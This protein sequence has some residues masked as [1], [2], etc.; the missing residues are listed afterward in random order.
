MTRQAR[1]AFLG[2][3]LAAAAGVTA[4]ACGMGGEDDDGMVIHLHGRLSVESTTPLQSQVDLTVAGSATNLSGTGRSFIELE[5]P[6]RL[7]STASTWSV[8]GT[9]EGNR[10][11]L[12]GV[13][14][15]AN[16]PDILGSAVTVEF[17]VKTG[18]TDWNMG[19]FLG[20]PL[21]SQT[22]RSKGRASVAVRKMELSGASGT[23]DGGTP[24]GTPGNMGAN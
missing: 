10:V 21:K 11:H 14:L 2:T 5:D 23:N 16:N 8:T 17:D 24:G 20:G 7:V 19:P 1:R 15:L 9:R 22:S 4:A 6:A 13:T 18:E 12:K 3:G